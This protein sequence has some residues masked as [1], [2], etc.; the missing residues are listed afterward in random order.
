MFSLKLGM[1]WFS[2]DAAMET[3]SLSPFRDTVGFLCIFMC[4]PNLVDCIC[5]YCRTCVGSTGIECLFSLEII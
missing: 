3:P 5:F 2:Y 4:V 1:L